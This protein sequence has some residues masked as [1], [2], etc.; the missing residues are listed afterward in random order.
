MGF[1]RQGYWSEWLFPSAGDLPDPGIKPASSTLAGGFFTTEPP[2]EYDPIALLSVYSRTNMEHGQAISLFLWCER[3]WCRGQCGHRAAVVSVLSLVFS[4]DQEWPS[5][6]LRRVLWCWQQG[7]GEGRLW[8]QTGSSLSA[9]YHLSQ[10][11]SQQSRNFKLGL[12]PWSS[13]DVYRVRPTLHFS[14]GIAFR[15]LELWAGKFNILCLR[16]EEQ[17][18]PSGQDRTHTSPYCGC[19]FRSVAKSCATLWYPIDYSTAGF[20]VLHHLPDFA[21][22]PVH[23]VGDV[24]QPSHP[25]LD[26]MSCALPYLFHHPCAPL[27]RFW[28]TSWMYRVMLGSRQRILLSEAHS[29]LQQTVPGLCITMAEEAGASWTDF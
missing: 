10:V 7:S 5:R 18:T 17:K 21:Q 9:V 26:V 24:I 19:C 25:L 12:C 6:E 1:S 15:F 3:A 13:L 2:G 27:T 14:S 11:P 20:P 8:S 4:E 23:W 22:T 29:I 28:N 16:W